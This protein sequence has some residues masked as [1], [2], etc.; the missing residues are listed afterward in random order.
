MNLSCGNCKAI[1]SFS[2]QP[3]T[4]DECGWVYTAPVGADTSKTNVDWKIVPWVLLLLVVVTTHFGEY[5]YNS[6]KEN[7]AATVQEVHGGERDATGSYS[8]LYM[9]DGT[10]WLVHSDF[11]VIA[12]DKIRYKN[13]G[14]ISQKGSG[15]LNFCYLTN[16]TR[17]SEIAAE[18]IEGPTKSTSCPAN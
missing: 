3:P 11:S 14:D 7:Q 10:V 15:A 8:K 1:R 4:C 9:N 5:L 13:E 6:Y 16:V 17:G 2:G 18:R 12:G